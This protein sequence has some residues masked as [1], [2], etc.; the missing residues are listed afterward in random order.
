MKFKPFFSYVYL[1]FLSVFFSA[2]ESSS[3]NDEASINFENEINDTIND[4]QQS[5][6]VDKIKIPAGG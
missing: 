4:D 1:V 6:Q 5:I 2:C 3:I